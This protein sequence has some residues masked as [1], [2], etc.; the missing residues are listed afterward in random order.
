MTEFVKC[1]TCEKKTGKTAYSCDK[2]KKVFC[3]ACGDTHCPNCG[4]KIELGG[5]LSYSNVTKVGY[6]K[7]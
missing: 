6:V 5:L 1:P 2:C 4:N 3:G 7:S